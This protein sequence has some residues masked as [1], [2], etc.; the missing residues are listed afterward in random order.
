MVLQEVKK[1]FHINEMKMSHSMFNDLWAFLNDELPST[2][3]KTWKTGLYILRL[4]TW[5]RM[6]AKLDWIYW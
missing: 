6:L 3:E 4:S 5:L 2:T 1:Q